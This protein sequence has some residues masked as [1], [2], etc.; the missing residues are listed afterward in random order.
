MMVV[1]I[2]AMPVA[3][4]VVMMIMVMVVI[5]VVMM[6]IMVVMMI[7]PHLQSA[8]ASAEGGAKIAIFDIAARRRNAFALDMMMVAFLRQPHFVFKPQHLRAVFA[9][10]AIHIV[11]ARQNF[12]HAIGK[13]R[14]HIIMVIE[15]TCFDKFEFRVARGNFI[16]EAVNAID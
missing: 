16:G 5:V 6:V 9:H 14:D 10:R 8:F 2:M 12:L 7:M 15:V 13:G 4:A 1:M 11:V 3:V